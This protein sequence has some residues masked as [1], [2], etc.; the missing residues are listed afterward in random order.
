[1]SESLNKK[2]KEQKII[3]KTVL[4]EK[5]FDRLLEKTRKNSAVRKN[6]N[7]E[8]WKKCVISQTGYVSI[9]CQSKVVNKHPFQQCRRKASMGLLICNF[10]GARSF[11]KKKEKQEFL[12]KEHGIYSGNEI[13]TLQK[14]LKEIE[15]ITPEQLMDISDELK[16]A[17]SLLRKYLKEIEEEKIARSPGT[18]IYLISEISKLKKEHFD[19]KH[20]REVSFTK[21]QMKFL[22]NQVCLILIELHRRLQYFHHLLNYMHSLWE[23][24]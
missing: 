21:E 5:V 9:R 23:S 11:E 20:S 17:I 2:R 16:L 24:W 22:F 1:M 18:L 4:K 19:M 13:K 6:Q 15:N 7:L 3:E 12:Q 14:E 8:G 10:H